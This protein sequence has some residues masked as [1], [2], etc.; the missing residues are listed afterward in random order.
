MGATGPT[1]NTSLK[2]QS[3]LDAVSLA[4]DTNG[5]IIDTQG[6]DGGWLTFV[7]NVGTVT[8]AGATLDITVQ[9][10]S[11]SNMATAV[12]VSG[13]A[14]TQIIQTDTT[15]FDKVLIG[16]LQ[17]QGRKRYMRLVFDEGVAITA[18]PISAVAIL[19][20]ATYS[21][22]VDSTFEFTIIG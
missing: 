6:F 17:L 3:A 15:T 13:A 10:D 11:A 2:M 8:G 14:M 1:P 7:V 9:E 16:T 12:A 20:G 18:C 19:Q 21:N 4:A 22:D 5:L